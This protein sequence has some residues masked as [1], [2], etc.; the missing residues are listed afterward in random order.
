[1]QHTVAVAWGKKFTFLA[2]Q[3]ALARAIRLECSRRQRKKVH[4]GPLEEL[5][6]CERQWMTLI[7]TASLQRNN[8]WQHS[9]QALRAAFKLDGHKMKE[10]PFTTDMHSE[11]DFLRHFFSYAQR[12]YWRVP[13]AQMVVG[14][15][16]ATASADASLSGLGSACERLHFIVCLYVPIQ[17]QM[18]TL[19]YMPHEDARNDQ[20]FVPI[21]D[22]E[23][24]SAIL[25]YAAAKCAIL[26]GHAIIES[27]WPV[28]RLFS[29]NVSAI[30]NLN[31]GSA[32]SERSR[33]LLR[34]YCCLAKRFFA[35]HEYQAY[36]RRGECAF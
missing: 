5:G 19:L 12:K 30:A 8:Q 29:D 1:L 18:R 3:A 16:H 14:S 2:L 4:V 25:A 21:N 15:H 6:P 7:S 13:I 32:R 31:K 36:P 9:S 26:F 11:L 27:E 28:L 23:L 33:A 17:I 24:A 34:I 20:A 35:M 22:L 10:A